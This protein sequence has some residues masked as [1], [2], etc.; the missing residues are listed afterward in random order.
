MKQ[1]YSKF[2]IYPEAPYLDREG[3]PV[4]TKYQDKSTRWAICQAIEAI[5]QSLFKLRT[6]IP[7]PLADIQIVAT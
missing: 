2:A 6:L 7:A 5:P 1:K 4:L 3:F